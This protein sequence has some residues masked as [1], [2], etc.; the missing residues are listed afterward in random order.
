MTDMPA[1]PRFA[2]PLLATAQAQ[3]EITHN[4]ALV[5][6][7]ALL[8]AA[9][10]A[11]PLAEPPPDAAEGQC[12]LVGAAPTGAWAGKTAAI[13]IRSAGG[14]RFAAAREGMSVVRLADGA[15]LRF[16]GGAW[17]V[18][19]VVTS[20]SAGVTIDSEARATIALLIALLAS[21]G[22]LISG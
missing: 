4:E 17:V 9:V 16:E 2:L 22:L 20:P 3:K 15:R 5:L 21:H 12:W 1:T 13:A 19:P 7:D 8:H 18:P 11:G 14:W 6:V 10:I